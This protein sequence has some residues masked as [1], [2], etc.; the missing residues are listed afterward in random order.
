MGDSGGM[1]IL[2]VIVGAVLVIGII[3]FAF[4]ERIGFGS[5]PSTTVK[6]EAP[7]IPATK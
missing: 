6:V 7:R 3:Y 4:G 1:G 2:G 5:R